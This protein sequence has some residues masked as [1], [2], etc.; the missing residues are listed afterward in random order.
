[1]HVHHPACCSFVPPHVLDALAAR[2]AQESAEPGPDQRTAL[3]TRELVAARQRNRLPAEGGLMAITPP[4]AG[5]T[6]RAIYDDQNT[7]ELR[8]HAR[9]RR[10]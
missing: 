6:D 4:T 9:P 10:G 7:M 8:R 1:M 3:V 2:D 5:D